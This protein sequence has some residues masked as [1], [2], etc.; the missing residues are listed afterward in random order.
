[1]RWDM[2]Q[3]SMQPIE[4]RPAYLYSD[5]E[6]RRVARDAYVAWQASRYSVPWQYAGKEVWVRE[7]GADVEVHYDG[8]RIAVHERAVSKHQVITQRVHHEGIPLGGDRT[9]GKILVQMRETAPAVETRSLAAYESV[10]MGG[11]R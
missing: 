3:F 1:M 6:L 9:G 11:A 10:A 7:Q 2:E 8:R 5:D 4:N